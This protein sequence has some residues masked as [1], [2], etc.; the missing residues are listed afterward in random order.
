VLALAPLVL[1]AYIPWAASRD[2]FVNW[3][4]ARTPAGVI[5]HV[6]G[7]EFRQDLGGMSLGAWWR[8]LVHYAGWPE[9]HV[10]EGYLL[11]QF[12]VAVIWLAPIGIWALARR[13]RRLLWVTLAA[14]AAPVLWMLSVR[15]DPSGAGYGLSHLIV[16]LWIGVGVREVAAALARGI[17]RMHVERRGRKRI[18]AIVHLGILGLPAFVL[19]GNYGACD[20]SGD[21]GMVAL[22]KAALERVA[23]GSIVIASGDDWAFA[24]LYVQQ[25]QG[26][27]RDVRLVLHPFF[28][29][30]NYRL[31]GR[32]ARRGV[33]VREPV[34]RHRGSSLHGRD[35]AWCRVHR[36]IWD[37]AS[38]RTTYLAGPVADLVAQSP[39][40]RR[41]LPPF[42][43]VVG[44]VQLLEFTKAPPGDDHAPEPTDVSLPEPL[45]GHDH[46]EH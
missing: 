38:Q 20:R 31:I 43:R 41:Q 19:A 11:T 29:G 13:R 12:S 18:G 25:V 17:R 27:R 42:R 46:D 1:Y 37:N 36:V 21:K 35:H 34:C 30:P 24:M 14:Y 4:D 45:P 40:A 16:V 39:V 5:A 2:P 3:G 9:D 7:G 32:E 22:G 33:V 44:Q 6:T 15:P 26:V 10:R 23:Q 28:R 8:N